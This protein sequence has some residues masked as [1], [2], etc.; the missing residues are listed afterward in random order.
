MVTAALVV[1]LAVAPMVTLLEAI[2]KVEATKEQVLIQVIEVDIIVFWDL[3][4]ERV[5]KRLKRLI[6]NLQKNITQISL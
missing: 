6:V 5:K 4:M 1:A 2:D 3:K